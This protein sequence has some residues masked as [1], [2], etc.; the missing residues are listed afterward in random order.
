MKK[1]IL[2]SL[3]MV[4]VFSS[5]AAIKTGKSI[6]YADSYMLRARGVEAAY[7]NPANLMAGKYY[8]LWVPGVNTGIFVNNNALDLDTY[9][10]VMSQERL[11]NDDKQL[12]L[13]KMDGSLRGSMRGN[14]SIFGY[15]FE[16]MSISSSLTV[17]GKMSVSKDYLDLLLN[18][19]TEAEYIF[20]TATNDLAALSFVDITFGMGGINIP[21]LPDKIP[22]IRFGFSA[23]ALAGVGNAEIEEYSG[24]LRSSIDSGLYLSQ[25]L[26]IRT[27]IG[28][29]GFKGM[30][31]FA[32]NP[33]PGLE[34]GLTLDNIFGVIKWN[35]ITENRNYSFEAD[36]IYVA[37]INEDFY[38]QTKS[39]EDIASYSTK[40]P[41]ELRLGALWTYG[42]YS[43]STD[44]VQGFK[45][46][47][48]TSNIGRFSLATQVAPISWLPFSIGFSTGDSQNPWSASY[49][50]SLR[51]ETGEIGLAVQSFETLIPNYK[52]KGISFGSFLRINY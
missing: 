4:I 10:Y 38:T 42:I 1:L 19:N 39:T 35:M 26:T 23:S 28:G 37:N 13:G 7:W 11:N 40:L 43:F 8:D 5:L 32:S 36:S 47:M 2:L 41:A 52:T 51:S 46:S 29:T 17:A 24:I 14:T 30:I 34:V 27:A 20:D 15:A 18:G 50:I 12:I 44:Y 21:Y 45:N 3:T 33:L 48:V 6:F 16:N 9:N 22:P 31:G 25:D 49:G